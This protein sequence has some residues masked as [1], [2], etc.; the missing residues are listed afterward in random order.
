MDFDHSLLRQISQQLRDDCQSLAAQKVLDAYNEIERLRA[1][2]FRWTPV[3]EH[4]DIPVK[5][6]VYFGHNNMHVSCPIG[7]LIG[8]KYYIPIPPLHEATQEEKDEALWDALHNIQQFDHCAY[9]AKS[10][11]LAGLKAARG[12]K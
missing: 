2:Q 10:A 6:L 8:A 12:E 11:F 1:G 7:S 4:G 5:A 3:N 9:P